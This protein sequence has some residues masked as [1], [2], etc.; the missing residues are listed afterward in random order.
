MRL[1]LIAGNGRFPFLVLEAARAQGHDVTV[2]AVKEE[3]SPDLTEAAARA[4]ATLHWVSLGQPG[5]CLRI[6]EDAGVTQAVMAGQVKHARIFS[7]GLVP[8]LTF[9]SVIKKVVTRSTDGLIGAVADL[10]KE[11]GIELVNSTALLEPLLAG[12]GVLTSRQPTD[13]E[14]EDFAFA[15]PVADAVA[16]FD[17]G[18]TVV[19]KQRAVVAIEAMEGTDEAIGRAGRV[20]G[21]GTRVIKVA[22][23]K[24]DMRFDV[25][26][27]G[28]ATI[29]AMR[30]AGASALSV[31]AGRTLLI[32]G[33][34]IITAAND[35]DIA[36]VGRSRS[37]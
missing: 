14:R 15:Y 12:A 6:L 17:V 33:P 16:G 7:G 8:D 22:K 1:G 32:D 20:A 4:G 24:Q 19:V 3:A 21:A 9:L 30:E 5:T 11:R 36:I 31:D 27:V 23:P 37:L 26:V 34:A 29:A 25:P 28:L 13:D 2:V 18:Q 35:A 10:L